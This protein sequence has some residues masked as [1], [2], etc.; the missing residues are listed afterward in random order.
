M[1]MTNANT[2]VWEAITTSDTVS[3]NYYGILCLTAGSVVFKSESGGSDLTVAMSA[4]Q[5]LP[6][7]V[8]LVKSTGTSGTYAGAKAS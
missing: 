6:G 8:V 2:P 4:G 1:A 7:R 3:Q 5:T